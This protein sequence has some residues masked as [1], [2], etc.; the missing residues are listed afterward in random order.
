MRKTFTILVAALLCVSLCACGNAGANASTEPIGSASESARA[1]ESASASTESSESAS[2]SAE[3]S[4]SAPAG[5][6]SAGSPLGDVT[7][8]ELKSQL[9]TAKESLDE[10]IGTFEQ[11]FETTGIED[12]DDIVGQFRNAS[13]EIGKLITEVDTAKTSDDLQAIYDHS[14]QI[15]GDLQDASEKMLEIMSTQL[16]Q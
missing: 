6:S 3:S 12:T 14:V 15:N 16:E 8:A 4:E 7:A 11:Y 5:G 13:D 9:E 10:S 2:A 1:S